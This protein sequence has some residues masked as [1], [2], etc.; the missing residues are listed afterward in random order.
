M[1]QLR[2]SPNIFVMFIKPNEGKPIDGI[3]YPSAQTSSGISCVLFADNKNC[4]DYLNNDSSDETKWL[5]LEA[6]ERK[7]LRSKQ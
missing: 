6:V 3:V 4:S 7:P 5:L 2:Y 1:Y